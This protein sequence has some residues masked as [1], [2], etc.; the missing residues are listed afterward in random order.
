VPTIPRPSRRAAAVAVLG[1]AVLGTATGCGAG[2]ASSSVSSAVSASARPSGNAL[3]G[4]TADQIFSRSVTDLKAASSVHVTGL[5]KD[6]GQVVA[7]NLTMGRKGCTGTMKIKGEGSFLLLM[8]GKTLWI[9]PDD[10]FWKATAGSSLTPAVAQL[11]LGKYIKPKAKNSS[12]GSLGAFCSPGQFAGMFGGQTSGV[13]KDGT[14]TIAGQPVL[15]LKD[16]GDV[17]FAYVTLSA[18]P[19]LLRLDAGNIGRFD[20]SRYN[21]RMR[22]TRPSASETLDGAK[23]GF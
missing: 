14:T 19:E 1:A 12:L 9:K 22:L 7:F 10:T 6:S 17:G 11:L 16:T 5:A 13:A 21:A 2:V 15:R 18:R 3:A 8:I 23:Y 20:F 4:L